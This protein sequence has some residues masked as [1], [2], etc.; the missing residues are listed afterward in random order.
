MNEV[1]P[2]H[3][4]CLALDYFNV[5]IPVPKAKKGHQYGDKRFKDL[6]TGTELLVEVFKIQSMHG[7]ISIQGKLKTVL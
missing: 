3:V 2:D 6:Q 4:G 7:I 1:A 5:S